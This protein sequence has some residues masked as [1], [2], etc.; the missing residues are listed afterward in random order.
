MSRLH[1]SFFDAPIAHRGLHDAK[2]G[3]IENSMGAVQ[4]AVREGYAIEI[5]VQPA[6]DMTPMVFHDY[7]LDRLTGH[8]GAI[9]ETSIDK[10]LSMRLTGSNDTIPTLAQVLAEIDGRV[11]LLVEI[12]DQDMRLGPNVGPFQ[13]SVSKLLNAYSGPAAIMSFSP[14][15]MARVKK[16]SLDVPI[17]LVTDPFNEENWPNVS[18]TRRKELKQIED[19]DSL[20]LDFI[21][22]QQTDLNSPIVKRIKDGGLSV[23]CWTIRSAEEEARARQIADNVTFEGY[24]P[25]RSH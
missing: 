23:F 24:T 10:L 1:P 12:K 3:I 2:Q 7:L 6:S 22:H 4:A 13:D 8:T 17:G 11:P 25:A 9:R 18:E 15:T 14:D 21:S 19:A 16:V 20:N 5:D